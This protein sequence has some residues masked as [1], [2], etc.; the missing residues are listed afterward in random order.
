MNLQRN[1]AATVLVVDDQEILTL[2]MCK[3]L[4]S[5]GFRVLWA[6]NGADALTLYRSAEPPI[7][8]LITDYRMPG[9]TG[10]QLAAECCSLNDELRVLFVSGSSPGD[11]LREALDAERRAFLAK[12]FRQSELLH[13]AKTLLAREPMV[14]ASRPE[15]HESRMSN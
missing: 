10:L 8:L 3:T 14:A 2:L 1:S 15:N 4:G 11:D 13:N 5:A 6:N 9:M 12:P 7:D